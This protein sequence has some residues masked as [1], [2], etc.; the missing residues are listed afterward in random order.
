MG[1]GDASAT[2]AITTPPHI[3]GKKGV[4]D[5][6]SGRGSGKG[7]GVSVVVLEELRKENRSLQAENSALRRLLQAEQ[8]KARET[9]N[10]VEREVEPEVIPEVRPGIRREIGCLPCWLGDGKPRYY[11]A[12]NITYY[13]NEEEFLISP[14]RHLEVSAS[15]VR[16]A[17]GGV[18][19]VG[20]SAFGSD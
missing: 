19:H 9:G 1:A 7:D 10:E 14:H 4:L 17:V 20:F 12:L 18:I 8:L 6:D 5:G 13:P 2:T 11:Y 16:Q 3:A 15:P